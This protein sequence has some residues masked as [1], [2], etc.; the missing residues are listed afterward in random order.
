[1]TKAKDLCNI[2]VTLHEL[3]VRVPPKQN[4]S[5]SCWLLRSKELVH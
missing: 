2:S 4:Y 5:S 3:P 1:V